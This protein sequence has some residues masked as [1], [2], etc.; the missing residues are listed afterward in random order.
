TIGGQ[1]VSRTGKWKPVMVFGGAVMVAGLG[2]LATIDHTTT[3]TSVAIYMALLGLGLGTLMQNTVL[4]VQNTV[5]VKD[6]GAASAAVAFFR[7]LGGAVGVSILGA[8]LASLVSTNMR[9]GMTDAGIPTDQ[10]D[11]GADVNLDIS[12]LPGPMQDLIHT[13]YADGFGPIFLIS[14]IAGVVTLLAILSVRGTMLRQTIG[15]KPTP[16]ADSPAADT[17]AADPVDAQVAATAEEPGAQ[18]EPAGRAPTGA[19]ADRPGASA[20]DAD[21]PVH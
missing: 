19:A 3:Y 17:D 15:L 13:A 1:I 5:D 14:A 4:A 6:I 18:T 8:V 2:G 7:S 12:S 9:D 20:P 10:L 11:S 21:V 16:P